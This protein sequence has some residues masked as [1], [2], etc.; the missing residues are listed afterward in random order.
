MVSPNNQR[1]SCQLNS[2]PWN[3]SPIT[4]RNSNV[5][6]ASCSPLWPNGTSSEMLNLLDE[7]LRI[8]S[9]V[10]IAAAFKSDDQSQEKYD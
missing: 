9:D 2:S 5:P 4:L 6:D 1:K 8:V 7:A 3:A 10:N